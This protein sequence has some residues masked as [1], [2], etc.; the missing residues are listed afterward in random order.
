[1]HL[2]LGH[3]NLNMIERLVKSGALYSLVLKDVLVCK[4]C[5]EDKMTKRPFTSEEVRGKEC[6]CILTCVDFLMLKHVESMSSLSLLLM[7]IIGMVMFI[8]CI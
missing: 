7:I 3:I 2:H 8:L 5:I 4:Y 1:M 6:L